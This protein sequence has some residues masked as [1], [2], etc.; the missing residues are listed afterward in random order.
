MILTFYHNLDRL[1]IR[2][3][4]DHS[5]RPLGIVLVRNMRTINAGL[6]SSQSE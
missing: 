2:S 5:N 3:N 1:D 6:M 4:H